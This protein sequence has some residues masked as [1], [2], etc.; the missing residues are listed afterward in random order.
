[1]K[2]VA[3]LDILGFKR[4]LKSLSQQEAKDYIANYSGEVYSVL[5]KTRNKVNGFIVSDSILLYTD[6]VTLDAL[7]SLVGIVTEV[8]ESEFSNYGIL[9]RGAIAKGEFDRMPAIELP[10]LQ[11]HLI[12]GQAYVDAY[13]L[14]GSLKTLGINL[15]KEVYEDL[16]NSDSRLDIIEEKIDNTTHYVLRYLSIDY[17]LEKANLEQ[18]IKLAKESKWLPHYYNTLYFSMKQEKDGK[19]VEDLFS[20]TIDSVCGGNPDKNWRDIDLFI[21]NAFVDDVISDYK[22]RFLKYIRQRLQ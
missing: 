22:T 8:S 20:K 6:D 2:Y 17:L 10:K 13:L 1:M 16:Q 9:I 18:F 15:A 11:K 4:R 19:K 7:N 5:Q 3:F 21:K 12:V 14:E